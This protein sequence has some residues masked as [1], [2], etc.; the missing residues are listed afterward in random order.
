MRDH[1][2][3]A[4]APARI[5]IP[6]TNPGNVARLLPAFRQAGYAIDVWS[7]P[8]SRL[9]HSRHVRRHTTLPLDLDARRA[10]LGRIA[11]DL[12]PDDLVVLGGDDDLRVIADA[13]VT[14]PVLQHLLPVAPEL[15]DAVGS[16]VGMARVLAR[17]GVAMPRHAVVEHRDDCAEAVA[18]LGTPALVKR[19]R[20]G[21]GYGVTAVRTL[22]DLQAWD[23]GA[24]PWLVEELLEGDL[25]SIDLVAVRGEVALAPYSDMAVTAG[26][27]GVSVVRTFRTLDDHRLAEDLEHLARAL[28][29]TWLA[30]VSAIRRPDGSH[31]V[32]EVDLRPNAWHAY[33]PRLGYPLIPALR[34]ARTG[35]PVAPWRR[36][37][38]TTRVVNVTRTV[39]R[40]L[41]GEPGRLRCLLPLADSLG[42]G[43]IGDPL[44]TLAE[45]RDVTRQ[46]VLARRAR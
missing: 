11:R 28:G 17:L 8:G 36:Q 20:S 1:D 34:S 25:V 18:A 3:G 40:A 42:H 2:G 7:P 10:L 4:D 14:D 26:A 44:L 21:G 43:H 30:N 12:A 27:F 19:D 15:R 6:T 45:A 22:A 37:V 24:G 13:A 23:A 35:A 33:A 41:T 46:V 9:K 38:R 31:A 32:F 29:G 16:K 39:Q 5:V